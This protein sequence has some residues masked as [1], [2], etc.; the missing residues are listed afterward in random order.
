MNYPYG[1]L[2]NKFLYPDRLKLGIAIFNQ[3]RG[4]IF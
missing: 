4:K 3:I 1:W 2:I